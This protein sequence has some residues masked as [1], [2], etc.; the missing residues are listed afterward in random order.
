MRRAAPRPLLTDQRGSAVALAL[1]LL[2]ALAGMTLLGFF[3]AHADLLVALQR[4]KERELFFVEEAVLHIAL[5]SLN[6]RES[7]PLPGEVLTS[8][9]GAYSTETQEG[10]FS[11]WKYAW[12]AS[13]LPDLVDEDG[14]P[15]TPSLLFS[16][17]FG[18]EGSPFASGGPA[19]VR[20]DVIAGQKTRRGALTAEIAPLS[21]TPSIEA[22][23]TSA[24]PL[25]LEGKIVVSGLNHC[26][27]GEHLP[28]PAEDAAGILSRGTVLP[29][30]D[31]IVAGAPGKAVLVDP[32]LEPGNDP[33]AFLNPGETL[34]SL[35][36][37]SSPG[38]HGEMLE[39]MTY[40]PEGYQGPMDGEGL[41]IV[42]NPRYDPLLYEASRRALEE[43]VFLPEYDPGYSHL[44]PDCQPA[45]LEIVS[46]GDFRGVIVADVVGSVF[47]RTRV[48]GALVTLG[49]SPASVRAE[50]EL[51]VLFSR[52][53]VGKACR[54]PLAHRLS[55]KS[56]P[57][58][59]ERLA[60]MGMKPDWAR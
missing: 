30:E 58:T 32:G 18:Y 5:S 46:G 34:S 2:F 10:T 13:L 33:L 52:D 39:G 56:L 51:E 9:P 42:H 26:F 16:R 57:G 54:G 11:G 36:A 29:G 45:V 40:A 47:E 50:A 43:G 41:L 20:I 23:W 14:D 35:D 44:D 38:G 60:R 49:R 27:E 3:A 53:A 24:G 4:K 12:R 25:S 1:A 31:V 8:P 17:A 22:A 59:P 7:S 21:M 28:A 19:V 6:D 37:L 55:F 15:A 48:V